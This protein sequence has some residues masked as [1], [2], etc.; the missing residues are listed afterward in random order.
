M[1]VYGYQVLNCPKN[2]PQPVQ[3]NLAKAHALLPGSTLHAPVT[4]RRE[5]AG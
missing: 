1:E 5:E 2:F 3:L 4:L